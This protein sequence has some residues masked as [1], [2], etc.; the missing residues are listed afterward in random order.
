V[1]HLTWISFG[2][3]FPA[4]IGKFSCWTAVTTPQLS[5]PVTATSATPEAAQEAPLNT[6]RIAVIVAGLSLLASATASLAGC[7]ASGTSISPPTQATVKDALLESLHALGNTSYAMS[8]RTSDLTASGSVDPIGDIATVTTK[9]THGGQPGKIEALA[10]QQDSWAKIDLGP[11]SKR[12]GISTSKWLLLDPSKLTE[13][14]L[15]FDESDLS[16]AF[17][18]GDVLNGIITVTRTDT[19]HYTGTL[20]LSGVHGVISL[21]P[22]GSGLADAQDVP[23]AATL[24]SEGRLT[25]LKVGGGSGHDYSFDFGISDYSAAATVDPPNDIDVV[26][27]PSAAYSLLRAENFATAD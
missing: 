17:D 8:L 2:W 18:L 7:H 6:R 27:A 20:D 9:G 23:F 24:D 25:D 19:R 4:R 15:P 11:A 16:D 12:M 26:A 1:S 5:H 3:D 13:G 14:S 22:A 10:I 21:V